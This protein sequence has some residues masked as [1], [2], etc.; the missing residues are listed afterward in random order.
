MQ[1]RR[2]L[3]V[4]AL[5]SCVLALSSPLA[6]STARADDIKVTRQYGLPYLPLMVM[7]HDQLLEKHLK[8]LGVNDAKVTW[9]T[10]ST[11]TATVD[12]LLSGSVDFAS[13]G[14]TGL[15]TLWD[16]AQGANEIK[17]ISGISSFPYPLVTNNPA[18]KTI[19][20]FTDKDK[21]AVPA[22]KI[23]V[24]A[25]V[26]QM[27]AAQAFGSDKRT[28]LDARTVS[29]GHP[30]AAIAVMSK[31]SEVDSHFSYPPYS[32]E[33]LRTPGVH[34]VLWANDVTN[35]PATTIEVVTPARVVKDHPKWV[36]AW[37]AAQEEANDFINKHHREA[38]QMYIAMTNEKK[39]SVD[40]LVQILADPQVRISVTPFNT[41]V[42]AKYMHE[43][44]SIKHLPQSW[45]DYFWPVA[46]GLKGS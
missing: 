27:A 36:D 42:F 19:K 43:T 35:G 24:Q 29:L 14:I 31:Q 6:I 26:L 44:G 30:Q 7:E 5:L 18:V 16:K 25:I 23:S 1:I 34:A 41:M 17:A 2:L 22:V 13:S 28:A 32:L 40:D 39:L 20:D 8:R 33:E 38:A 37:L 10:M 45:K 15:L 12:G 4:S 11:T 46:H 3:R 21:I 9:A